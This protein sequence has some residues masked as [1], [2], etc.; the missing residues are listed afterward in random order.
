V[1]DIYHCEIQDSGRIVCG[2]CLHGTVSMAKDS[3]CPVCGAK[4][5]FA[6]CK[7]GTDTPEIVQVKG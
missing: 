6:R 7:P 3:K 2:K 5:I 4:V 1:A